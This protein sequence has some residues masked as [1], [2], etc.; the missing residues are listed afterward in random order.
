M[1][2][3]AFGD[4]VD[5]TID[6][7]TFLVPGPNCFATALRA[8]GH[9]STFRGVGT[10]EFTAFLD[11]ACEAVDLPERGDIGT[12]NPKNSAYSH[13]YV[14]LNKEFGLDKPGVDYFGSTPVSKKRLSAIDYNNYA[15]RECRQYS[16]DVTLCSNIRTHFR[17]KKWDWSQYSDLKDHQIRVAAWEQTMAVV[18]ETPMSSK[19][20]FMIELDLIAQIKILEKDVQAL[21]QL[22]LNEKI[23]TYL[24]ARL[25][26]LQD[27]MEFLRLKLKPEYPDVV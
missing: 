1:A 15:S 9:Y 17:C 7:K 27:Q 14:H 13:A 2:V 8:T 4:I 10:S 6:G 26:S 20:M 19:Q 22:P 5:E 24:A 16:P 11:M 23:K 3:P 25:K 21:L 18:L 12:Y